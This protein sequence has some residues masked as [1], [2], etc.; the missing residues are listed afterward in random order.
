M[1]QHRPLRAEE[2]IYVEPPEAPEIGRRP[3]DLDT[4]QPSFAQTKRVPGQ[5]MPIHRETPVYE[6]HYRAAPAP[7]TPNCVG[8]PAQPRQAKRDTV[9]GENGERLDDFVYQ[10]RREALPP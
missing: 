3:L 2:R 8:V 5:P 7:R 4:G 10:V 1:G 6:D 9:K